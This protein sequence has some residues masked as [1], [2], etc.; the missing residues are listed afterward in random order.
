MIAAAEWPGR[1]LIDCVFGNPFRIP[2]FDPAWR[3]ST[4]AALAGSIYADAAFDRQPILADALEEA[5]CGD[6]DVLSHCRSD[7]LHI[8]G[9]W[10]VDLALGKS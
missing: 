7:G 5:G 10:V 4:A 2:A 8:R 6:A 1:W 3:T 9:C